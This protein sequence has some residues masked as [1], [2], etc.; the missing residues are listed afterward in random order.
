MA[1]HPR[2]LSLLSSKVQDSRALQ[3]AFARIAREG[4]PRLSAFYQDE[5]EWCIPKSQKG[6][7][8]CDCA[9]GPG[10]LKGT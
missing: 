7:L 2:R 1:V 8:F 10:A 6:V 3:Q 5:H 4:G 9:T